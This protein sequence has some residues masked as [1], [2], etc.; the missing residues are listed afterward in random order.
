MW[1]NKAAGHTATDG[2]LPLGPLPRGHPHESWFVP[3]RDP[4]PKQQHNPSRKEREERSVP[5]WLDRSTIAN[6]HQHGAWTPTTPT[7]LSNQHRRDRADPSLAL[8]ARCVARDWC[9]HGRRRDGPTPLTASRLG[10]F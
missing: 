4:S 9:R 5:T 3:V 1:K 8:C 10:R 7:M 6:H 2:T